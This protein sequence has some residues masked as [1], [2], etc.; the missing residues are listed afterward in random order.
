M[1]SVLQHAWVSF[2]LSVAETLILYWLCSNFLHR[3]LRP[4]SQY[5][6]GILI[7]FVFQWM[8]YWFNAPL[9]S[10]CIFYCAFTMLVSCI[11]FTDSLRTKVLVAYLFVVLNYA[12]KLLSAVLVRSLHGEPLPSEPNFLIQSPLAQMTA[13]VLFFF[14]TLLFILCRNMRKSNKDTLYNAISF[15]V[16][17]VILFITIQI[18]HMKDSVSHFYL[19]ISGILFCSSMFLFYLVDDY[20]I[21][22]EESQ[23]NMIADKL[24]TMQSSYYQKVEDS[25]REITSLRHDLKKHLHS[26][27]VFLK[28]GQ[29]DQALTYIEQI[30]ESANGMKVPLTGGNSMVNILVNNAEQQAAACNVPLTANIMVPPE[31]PVENVDLCIILGNLLDNALEACSRM[32][33]GAQRFI[34]TEIRCRKAFLIISISNSY[35]GQLRME[36]N[37]YESMKIGEQYCGIGLSNVSTVIHKYNG[38]MKISHNNDVFTVSV[39]LPLVQR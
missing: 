8:T 4:A 2:V 7:Y 6:V 10:M 31:L 3:N 11:F 39:M 29:Y 27:V 36:G 24:L 16:P 14:F 13:C 18:F 25:Q 33:K 34:H 5:T 32:G 1:M 19:E 15:L 9:F 20:A 21:I 30:Y 12:C 23:K 37:R 26:L 17:S 28:A 38:D 22:N 35:N